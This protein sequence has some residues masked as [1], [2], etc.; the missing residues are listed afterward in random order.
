LFSVVVLLGFCSV[1]IRIDVCPGA[2]LAGEND[3]A[4][5]G[6]NTTGLTFS[7]ATAEPVAV[8]LAPLSNVLMKSLM[9]SFAPVDVAV[10]L[11]DAVHAPL[12]GIV[13]AVNDSVELPAAG[14]HTGVPPQ[15][16]TAETVGAT[17]T[18]GGNWSTP[19]RATSSMPTHC[20]QQWSMAAAAR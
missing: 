20:F 11:T 1:A 8:T 5:I 10:T 4:A 7:V 13:P 2:M 19:I 15:V 9:L 17:T 6:G 3:L 14:D 18:P 16:D 12:A